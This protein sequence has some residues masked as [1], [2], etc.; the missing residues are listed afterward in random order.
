MK[1][2]VVLSSHTPSLFWF[3]LDMMVSFLEKGYQVYALGN[4]SELDWKAKFEEK[5][6]EYQQIYVERN[7]IN[8][9]NDLKTLKSI[10]T[11]LLN[12]KPNKIF[13]FQA[14][15]V[16]YG[17]IAASQLE[18]NE[19]YPLIAGMGSVF[20]R[21]DIKTRIVRFFL[22][23]EYRIGMRNSKAVFFQNRDDEEIFRK[24]RI[25]SRQKVELLPGSGVNLERF[26][27]QKLPNTFGLLCISRLIRDKGVF[28]YLEACR[29]LKE[30]HPNIRCLLVGPFDSNPSALKPE[31][32]QSYI[33]DGTIEFFGEQENVVPYYAQCSVFV[34]PSYREGTPKTNLEAMACERAILTTDAPGCKETVRQ[35]V[36]G[37]MVPIKD[38]DAIVEGIEYLINNPDVV[39][40]MAAEGRR[41]AENYFDVKIVNEKICKVMRI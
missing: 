20:L 40:K 24:Y 31:E 23:R 11:K 7:G 34:L 33:D 39:I 29:R 37:I 28:E 41:M 26:I 22:I 16:I 1:K 2:I 13:A 4:E 18:I 21:D 14:K 35:G 5:G 15:T 3:R 9:L 12:I 8:P 30:K 17:G 25:I 10:K 36:N 38:V 6:I 19:F 32:L 27:P